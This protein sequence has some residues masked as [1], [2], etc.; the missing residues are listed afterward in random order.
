M[1]QSVLLPQTFLPRASVQLGRLVLNVQQPHSDFLPIPVDPQD[2]IVKPADQFQG[3]DASTTTKEFGSSLC[4][5]L[6]LTR[7]KQKGTVTRITTD[8][9]TTYLLNNSGQWFREVVQNEDA[10]KWI[11]NA[12]RRGDDIYLV[13]GFHTVL[14]A[15]VYETGV[16][17]NTTTGSAALPVAEALTATG[18]FV[19]FGEVVD[20]SMTGRSEQQQG[21]QQSFVATGE[22]ISAV[23]YRKIQ[24]KWHT[25]RELHDKPLGP[26][27]WKTYWTLRGDDH[28]V[29][30]VDLGNDLELE[31]DSGVCVYD[32]DNFSL[33][34][35]ERELT[36]GNSTSATGRGTD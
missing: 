2:I 23:Q 8:R 31:D 9:V 29:V 3:Q 10:R 27:R 14:D 32:E 36:D 17:R 11:E 24:F 22:Q 34:D 6:S 15:H 5:L 4:H 19:P 33:V 30:E 12:N 1:S 13:A 7:S 21:G 18:V 35:I 25:S 28:D 26:N 20:P 16:D